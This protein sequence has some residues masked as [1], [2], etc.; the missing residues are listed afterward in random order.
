MKLIIKASVLM[1]CF[2]SSV[3]A[4]A[5]Y[6]ITIGNGTK[7]PMIIQ[8]NDVCVPKP[9]YPN[10]REKFN[11]ESISSVCFNSGQWYCEAKFYLNSD[12]NGDPVASVL[13]D[14]DSGILGYYPLSNSIRF[15][16]HDRQSFDIDQK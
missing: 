9:I 5:G 8:W 12:C 16:W 7:E 1:F 4:F 15:D 11:K 10:N 13:I 14:K 2:I 6:V 3:S